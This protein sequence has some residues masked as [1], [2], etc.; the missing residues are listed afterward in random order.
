MPKRW[1]IVKR[2]KRYNPPGLQDC[3]GKTADIAYLMKKFGIDAA[4]IAQSVG[5]W[6]KKFSK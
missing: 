4:S 6:H 3:F 5:K 1:G 2:R